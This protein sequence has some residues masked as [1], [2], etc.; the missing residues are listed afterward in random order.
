MFFPNLPPYKRKLLGVLVFCVVASFCLPYLP[1]GNY[2]AWPLL[3]IS[4]VAH[5]LGHG[6]AA[7]LT[8]AHFEGLTMSLD[9]SGYATT[10]MVRGN[11]VYERV[12]GAIISLGGL[13]GP[14][15]V[16][17]LGFKAVQK[18]KSKLFLSLCSGLLFFVLITRVHGLFAYLFIG[19]LTA[20]LLLAALKFK[21][22]WQRVTVVFLSVQLVMSVFTRSDYL[23][24]DSAGS[25]PSDVKQIE[26]ALFLPYW[27]WGALIAVFSVYILYRGVKGFFDET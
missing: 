24:T 10:A 2:I 18:D 12:A 13:I 1:Y 23:F 4:T 6:L 8:L 27:L 17:T 5:E 16:A 14:A 22:E 26:Q 9:A 19:L 20:F 7:W 3:L 21:E 15:L 25:G 11:P